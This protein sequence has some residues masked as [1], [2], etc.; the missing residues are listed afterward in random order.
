[1]R[2]SKELV[3]ISGQRKLFQP[4]QEGE[5]AQGGQGR[6]RQGQGD[7][8]VDL[9]G[10]SP[11]HDGRLL[12]LLRKLEEVLAHEEDGEG[13]KEP[14]QDEG[15]VGVHPAQVPHKY[16]EGDDEDV[17]GDHQG[18]QE[19]EE[20]RPLAPEAE[21]GE[22]VAG[23]SPAGQVQEGQAQGHD[24]GVQVPAGE[25]NAGENPLV[26]LKVELLR[27]NLHGQVKD[28]ARGLQAC[29]HHPEEGDQHGDPPQEEEEKDHA[30]P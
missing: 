14:G 29:G 12:Q 27:P 11:I 17:D 5:G 30:V 4:A 3:T 15:V 18:G 25:G 26:V 7:P 28:R 16:E 20:E 13:V 22:G 6:G 2:I 23:H 19:E 1:V 24:Q 8:P 10:G 9:P 21:A